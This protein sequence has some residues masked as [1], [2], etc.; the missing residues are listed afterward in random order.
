MYITAP[1]QRSQEEEKGYLEAGEIIRPV[2]F[3]SSVQDSQSLF[4]RGILEPPHGHKDIH[5]S[6]SPGPFLEG[7]R[8]I[9]T[10]IKLSEERKTSYTEADLEN[11][12][13]EIEVEETVDSDNE[14]G[15]NGGS[16]EDS[17]RSGNCERKKKT[18]TV[19]SRSQIFQLETMFD[20]KRYL[21][22]SERAGLAKAL[23]MTETQ[24]KIWF[25]N[26][27]NK[28][29]RQIAAEMEAANMSQVTGQRLMQLPY[30]Y[31]HE[32]LSRGIRSQL[33]VSPIHSGHPVVP[34]SVHHYYGGILRSHT[35]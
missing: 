13:V 31:G 26:R 23:N 18:R 11:D 34:P 12:M 28:W 8:D 1:G 3:R 16:G 7:R 21:S 17:L 5:S 27:R 24:V 32:E 35:S 19:F 2:A 4:K 9:D 22:S 33:P 15:E 6:S 25:Q 10:D 30:M 20:M 29:K 14:A